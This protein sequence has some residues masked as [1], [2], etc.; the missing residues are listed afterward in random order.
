MLRF[1]I[2]SLLVLA[3]SITAQN[4][5]TYN[6]S[7]GI[8]DGT[9]N[10]LL[11][12]SQTSN[13]TEIVDASTT[14]STKCIACFTRKSFTSFVGQATPS[15]D[16]A[17]KKI[18]QFFSGCFSECYPTYPACQ[19]EY[20]NYYEC[21]LGTV[22]GAPA[23]CVV[24]CDASSGA[25]GSGGGGSNNS[26]GKNGSS[27]SYKMKMMS[28]EFLFAITIAVVTTGNFLVV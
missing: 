2:F 21:T 20:D 22:L 18:C 7:I 16:D 4:T 23:N 24:Q 3:P 11:K 8:C 27:S 25:S 12:C 6:Y 1:T 9:L 17:T 10:A 19:T 14:D 13:S 26:T 15:C 5:P 28:M